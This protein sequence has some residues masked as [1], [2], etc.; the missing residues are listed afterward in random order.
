MVSIKRYLSNTSGEIA[1]RQAVRLLIEKLGDCAIH[2]YPLELQNFREETGAIHQALIPSLPNESFPVLAESAARSLEMYTGRI[3][4]L[5]GRQN[6][7]FQTIIRMLQESL[8][9]IAGGDTQ[10]AGLTKIS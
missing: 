3:N 8:L 4:R 10:S 7:D 1:L 5:I 6:D 2:A 9:T